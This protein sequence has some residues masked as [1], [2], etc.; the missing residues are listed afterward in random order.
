VKACGAEEES[1]NHALLDC[2]VA[3]YFWEEV[4]LLTGVKVPPL[5]PVTWACDL[6]DPDVI[7]GKDAAVILCGSW[8]LW[9]A[10]NRRRHGE[11]TV[12]VKIAVHLQLTQLL[13]YGW[14]MHKAGV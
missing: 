12:P 14:H 7:S 2:T 1:I 5:H 13:T 8:S 11:R 4:K 9:M 6:I 10:R 3:K